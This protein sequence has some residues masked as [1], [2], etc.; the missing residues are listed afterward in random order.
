[1]QQFRQFFA[2]FF[3]KGDTVEFKHFS[4]LH[5][6]PILI[7]AGVI[8]LIFRFRNQLR[9]SKYEK[10]LS[11]FLSFVAIITEMSYFWR[12]ACMPSLGGNAQ[13]HLPI[14]I[15]GWVVVF[16]AVLVL[17]KNQTL[18]DI[19]YF[20][21]FSGTIFGLVTPT[22]ITYTGPTRFRFYQFWLEHTIGFI[23]VFYMMFV[24][25]MRPTWR[26]FVKAAV[27]MLALLGVAVFVNEMLGDPA[28]YLF[29]AGV[30][31]TE[32]LLNILPKNDFLRILLMAS[33][34]LFMFFLSYLPWM[35]MDIRARRAGASPEEDA[36]SSVETDATGE[37]E[38]E[39]NTVPTSEEET[40]E[41]VTSPIVTE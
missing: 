35:I 30:E 9:N 25:K 10:N 34:V 20:W 41:I 14:T 3:G 26:S 23:I 36:G 24:H 19:S 40:S 1:M 39:T 13:E 15:C 29:V 6:L 33:I 5:F 12:M 17:T 7:A 4:I 22:V 16:C 28:N 11:L 18:F 38:A 32:S 27:A 8:F 21:L 31:D 37:T 2:Y